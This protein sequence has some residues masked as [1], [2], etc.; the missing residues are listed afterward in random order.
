M[1]WH[2]INNVQSSVK[3]KYYMPNQIPFFALTSTEFWDPLSMFYRD[4]KNYFSTYTVS[5]LQPADDN[6]TWP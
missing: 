1:F 4:I 3:K 5:H 6:K 2:S